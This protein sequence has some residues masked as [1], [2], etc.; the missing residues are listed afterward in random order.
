MKSVRT[1]M[2]ACV[3]IAGLVLA[4]GLG[5]SG[6]GA[7][8]AATAAEAECWYLAARLGTAA[9]CGSAAMPDPT[10]GTAPL[11]PPNPP[12]VTPPP[13]SGRI[14]SFRQTWPSSALWGKD[15]S[16]EGWGD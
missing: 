5:V 14:S 12:G 1:R 13:P 16:K 15:W 3:C 6:V 2:R 9:A 4:G 7:A 10:G 11:P 8:R